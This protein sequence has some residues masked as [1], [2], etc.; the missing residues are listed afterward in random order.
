MS[1]EKTA[2]SSK[3][4]RDLTRK[5]EKATLRFKVLHIGKQ[6][7]VR[8]RKTG[9]RLLVSDA[10]IADE[11]AKIRLTLWNDDIY[12]IQEGRHYS[13]RNGR[14]EIF[15]ESLVLSKGY[16]GE[17]IPLDEQIDHVELD[18]DMSKPFMGMPSKQR[19]MRSEEGRSFQ[20]VPGR[21]QRGYCSDKE[22]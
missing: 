10:I 1:Q 12:E 7:I 8:S 22:F 3:K 18:F 21:N 4:I 16:S 19:K 5:D 15:D 11:T 13:L 6:R 20:G 2:G 14:V 9:K 17:I